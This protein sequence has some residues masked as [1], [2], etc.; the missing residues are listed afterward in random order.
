MMAVLFCACARAAA[1][2]VPDTDLFEAAN[3]FYQQGQ[4]V[5][6][7]EA[8]EKL[9]VRQPDNA[10]YYYNLG[11]SYFR[12]DRI[13]QSLLAYE[14]ARMLAPRDSDIRRNLDYVRGLLEYRV[15]DKRSWYMRAGETALET[16]TEKEIVF[17]A[18]F[19]YF[20]L[21]F[22]LCVPLL[23]KREIR[24]GIVRKTLLTL[25]A[26]ALAFMA[27]KEIETKVIRDAIIMTKQAEV[28]FGPSDTDQVAFRLGEGLKV[29]VVRKRDLWSRVIL[30]NGETG[31]I[32]N[33]QIEEVLKK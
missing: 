12:T 17:L 18:S 27:G 26:V 6:A 11:N 5:Q 19:L 2:A 13:A 3:R 28:K 4:Y 24:W 23:F 14:R 30:V 21:V 1:A 22:S 33:N 25:L 16:L 7:I 29:Y 9:I 10:D 20:L 32:K 8:Y 31:W 15:E